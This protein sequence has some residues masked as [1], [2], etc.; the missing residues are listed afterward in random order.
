MPN[1]AKTEWSGSAALRSTAAKK[2]VQ[3]MSS[4][5][6][7]R[8]MLETR[9]AIYREAETIA[10]LQGVPALVD[11]LLAWADDAFHIEVFKDMADEAASAKTAITGVRS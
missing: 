5:T 8:Q 1:K 3:K 2:G 4:I 11:I 10:R 9:N 7:A 6:A